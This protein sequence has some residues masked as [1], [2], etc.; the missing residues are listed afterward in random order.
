MGLSPF[1]RMQTEKLTHIICRYGRKALNLSGDLRHNIR[2]SGNTGSLVFDGEGYSA[3]N[4]ASISSILSL[5]KPSIDEVFFDIGCGRG[6]VVSCAARLNIKKVIGIETDM[7]LAKDA[8]QNA[9]R[10]R[11]RRAPIEILCCDAVQADYREGTIFYLYNP[12]GSTTLGR[13]LDKLDRDLMNQRRRVRLV[14]VHP[15]HEAE[16]E[17]R[18]WT[19][20][21]SLSPDRS[22]LSRRYRVSFWTKSY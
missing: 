13:V 5:L 19:L 20:S 16:L 14:Y 9:A 7:L 21:F 17:N 22:K 2:T 15:Q 8:Q 6:R 11:Q 3:L 4:Y 12:F 18:N 10:L 1:T